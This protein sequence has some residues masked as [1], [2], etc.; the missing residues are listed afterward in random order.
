MAEVR[1]WLQ[2][3]R[4]VAG[5]VAVCTAVFVG[6]SARWPLV[7]DATYLHYAVVLMRHGMRPYADLADMNLPGAYLLEA[8]VMRVLGAGS[9][10]WRVW[11][12]ALLAVAG[13]A[14]VSL[15]RAKGWAAG[16]IAAGMFALLH[17]QDGVIMAGE[18]DFAVAVL[19]LAA[20]ALL[21]GA[22]RG[23]GGAW[24]GGVGFGVLAGW[25]ATV[26]PTAG[27]VVVFAVGWMVVVLRR[28]GERWGAALGWVL[29]GLVV[30]VVVQGVWLWRLGVVRAFAGALTGIVRYHA[31]LGHRPMA[32][33]VAH[34]VS[35]IGVLVGV[36]VVCAAGPELRSGRG[37]G[38][39]ERPLLLVCAAG[40]WVSY[41]VQAKGFSYQRYPFLVFLLV[42]MVGDFADAVAERGRWT[43]WAGAA[44]LGV[45]AVLAAMFV[46]RVV[47]FDRTEPVRPL[48]AD[49]DALGGRGL[50]VQCMDTAGPCIDAL[51]ASGRVQATGFVYDCYLLD[52][53]SAVVQGL[54]RRFSEQVERGRPE[55]FVV[56]D[57]VCYDQP[58][59]LESMRGGR[60]FRSI[61]RR[62]MCC[63]RSGSR[64]RGSGIG[65]GWRCRLRTGCTCGGD[66]LDVASLA[67]SEDDG[68]HATLPTAVCVDTR[69]HLPLS[70]LHG[71]RSSVP[72]SNRA[73]RTNKGRRHS[74]GWGDC[75]TG[76]GAFRSSNHCVALG[77]TICA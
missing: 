44:G 73:S 46:R 63:G 33:L 5:W 43:R 34:S 17:G 71:V 15:L 65:A 55:V 32:Y 69:R 60:S 26:K 16:V 18:R 27:L 42:V 57:S 3:K 61:W 10:G 48:V 54:R 40:G 59:G 4:L 62:T 77:H 2:G 45:V 19:L 11:D 36:W 21:V 35:P 28:R 53:R 37:W 50:R 20:V 51:L 56:T 75:R 47:T 76:R 9:A 68:S 72:V 31:G 49:L 12:L 67:I 13:A 70:R 64:W 66:G 74:S 38:G 58:R 29:A 30:P 24:W 22:V 6:V 23:A 8:G 39:A 1:R 25:A 7:G 41:V 14:M 52:G